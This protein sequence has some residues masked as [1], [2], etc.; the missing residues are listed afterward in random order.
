MHRGKARP[1]KLSTVCR[2][3]E[4]AYTRRVHAAAGLPR[5][6]PCATATGAIDEAE[7]TRGVVMLDA[8]AEKDWCVGDGCAHPADARDIHCRA[9]GDAGNDEGIGHPAV[10]GVACGVGRREA[11]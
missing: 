5:V 4:S 11:W 9:R 10:P 6:L 3:H 7:Q 8:A 1:P 2:L